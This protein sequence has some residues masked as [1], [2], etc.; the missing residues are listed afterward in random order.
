MIREIEDSKNHG[1]KN[2]AFLS[3]TKYV[4]MKNTCRYQTRIHIIFTMSFNRSPQTT[5]FNC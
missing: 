4:N 5:E 1:D 2:N 3:T